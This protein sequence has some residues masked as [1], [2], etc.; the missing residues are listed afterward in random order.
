MKGLGRP[1]EFTVREEDFQQWSKKT[2]TFFAGANKES[3]MMLEWAAEQTVEITTTAIDLG[4]LVDGYERGV[5]E[6]KTWSSSCSRCTQC[7]WTSQVAKQT[8]WSTTLGRI[9]WRRDDDY[10]NDVLPSEEGRG[11]SFAQSFL[12]NVVLSYVSRY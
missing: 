3:E 10:R 4:V 9:H 7:K 11:T 1:K 2:E 8:T 12:R 6:C 5:E